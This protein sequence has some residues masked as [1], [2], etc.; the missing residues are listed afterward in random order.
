M[1]PLVRD[2]SIH[3]I[4]SFHSLDEALVDPAPPGSILVQQPRRERFDSVCLFYLS[5]LS[6]SVCLTGT[7]RCRR[8]DS[9]TSRNSDADEEVRC[10]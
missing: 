2:T 5:V 1:N 9:V 10:C 3:S 4:S 6:L 7:S 8:F